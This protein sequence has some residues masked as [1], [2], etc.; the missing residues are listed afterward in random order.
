[1][2]TS[3][4]GNFNLYNLERI[5]KLKSDKNQVENQLFTTTTL[6]I[7]TS[8]DRGFSPLHVAVL[9][10]SSEVVKLLLQPLLDS[11]SVHLNNNN[12]N[13]TSNNK[14]NDYNNDTNNYLWSPNFPN[15]H[16][17]TPLHLAYEHGNEEI[18]VRL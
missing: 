13:D 6:D 12:E 18:I 11:N 10:N 8:D 1:M 7:V 9:S 5:D 4:L 2:N 14:K 3:R 15:V 16:L 17:Q